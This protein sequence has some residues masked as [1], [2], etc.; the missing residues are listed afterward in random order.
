MIIN[1][2]GKM[3]EPERAVLQPH[4]EVCA[5]HFLDVS[6]VGFDGSRGGDAHGV[7]NG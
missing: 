2:F 3:N 5:L 7:M 6:L 1:V 4:E